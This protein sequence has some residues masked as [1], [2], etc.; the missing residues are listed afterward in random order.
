MVRSSTLNT[1][2]QSNQEQTFK[3]VNNLLTLQENPVE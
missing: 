1:A 3:T 2:M